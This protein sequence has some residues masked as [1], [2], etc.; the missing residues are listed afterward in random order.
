M[1]RRS[2]FWVYVA[3]EGAV[4][5]LFLAGPLLDGSPSECWIALIPATL[6][7]G[8][9]SRRPGVLLGCALVSPGFVY[10][11]IGS[12]V[13]S[14]WFGLRGH[15]LHLVF[16]G[17]SALPTA[18]VAGIFLVGCFRAPIRKRSG[19][20]RSARLLSRIG[21]SRQVRRLV[22]LGG[23]MAVLMG[24]AWGHAQCPGENVLRARSA[25]KLN[26]IG[27]A[28]SWYRDAHDEKMRPDLGTLVSDGLL[29]PDALV[30]PWNKQEE[31]PASGGGS[32][33][34]YIFVPVARL[35]A[36]LVIAYDQ[37]ALDSGDTGRNVLTAGYSVRWMNKA[38]FRERLAETTRYLKG[39]AVK[40]G[41][42]TSRERSGGT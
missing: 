17:A 41:D 37:A 2:S 11:C 33:Y 31:A 42:T 1:K 4:A 10:V 15:I 3:V 22:Y 6:L 23:L 40:V 8:T 14:L 5:A 28:V 27:R 7:A 25:G 16:A 18:I 9:L 29:T 34:A 26:T 19:E 20:T 35:P 21:A 39:Q 30:S 32:D 36:D 12:G 24:M 13:G 38:A